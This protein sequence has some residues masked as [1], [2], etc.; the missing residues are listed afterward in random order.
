MGV[1]RRALR[2][3]AFGSEETIDGGVLAGKP[4]PLRNT[5]HVRQSISLLG[6]VTE[7]RCGRIQQQMKDRN[8]FPASNP[9]DIGSKPYVCIME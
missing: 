2:A 6:S 7:V 4:P 9:S 5:A 3:G 1:V 8:C